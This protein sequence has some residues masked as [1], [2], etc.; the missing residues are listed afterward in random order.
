MAEAAQDRMKHE[1]SSL[2]EDLD[3]SLIRPLQV[4]NNLRSLTRLNGK[5]II[6]FS[7]FSEKHASVCS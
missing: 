7:L 3:R 6:V 1:V 2:V 5:S 4:N